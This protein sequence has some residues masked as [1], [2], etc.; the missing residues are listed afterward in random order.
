MSAATTSTGTASSLDLA[1]GECVV[2]GAVRYG[3]WD[4]WPVTLFSPGIMGWYRFVP[5]M[6]TY[7]GVLSM[8]HSLLGSITIDGERDLLRPRARLRREGLGPFVSQ[9]VDLGAVEQFR[10][11]G[12]SV[13]VSVAKIPW[14]GGSFVGNIAGLLHDGALRRFAT[15]T[16]ARIKLVETGE[17]E[18]HLVI[19]DRRE[20]L[21]LHLHGCE[22][23][24]LKAP[25]LGAMEGR[26]A[27]SLGGTIDVT[28]R[29]VRGG[30]AKVVFEGTGHQAG[31]EIMNDRG[32]LQ[33]SD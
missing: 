3:P 23:L 30:R 9:L 20:E 13:M 15:Y 7:H 5:R 11:R 28:L 26:D 8:D 4:P 6:E 24:I 14:M 18:A 25:V 29:A 17:N 32:E 2:T 22:T 33:V 1:D 10:G 12:T 31:I 27:E 16:G 19:A 21:E